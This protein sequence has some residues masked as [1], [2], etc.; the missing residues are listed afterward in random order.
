MGMPW[1]CIGPKVPGLL[2]RAQMARTLAPD[3]DYPRRRIRAIDFSL[4]GFAV[5]GAR[6]KD[7]AAA[8]LDGRVGVAVGETGPNF[9]AAYSTG[10]DRHF[11]M[12]AYRSQPDD[13]WRSQVV[14]EAIHAAFDLAK[15]KPPNEIDEA[16]AYLGETIWFRAG[17]LGRTVTAPDAAAAIYGAANRIVARLDLHARPGQRLR[18]E[19]VQEL[20]AAI[21]GHPGYAP[22]AT[23]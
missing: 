22:S 20:I 6:L 9:A 12:G 14:H 11:T 2:L 1:I 15:E 8:I 5:S 10:P 16:A 23:P 21:N 19:Q 13:N 4:E 7:V 18:R 3:D 17:G